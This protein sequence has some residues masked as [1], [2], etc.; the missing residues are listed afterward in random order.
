MT[1]DGI[2]SNE[3]FRIEDGVSKTRMVADAAIVNK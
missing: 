3:W 1:V 2:R